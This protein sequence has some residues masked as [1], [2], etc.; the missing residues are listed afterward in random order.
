M[1]SYG[2]WGRAAVLISGPRL[3]RSLAARPDLNRPYSE[4]VRAPRPV[5]LA[6]D[7][8]AVLLPILGRGC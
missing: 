8:D 2:G 4:A 7:P 1:V 3:N 6:D 5:E